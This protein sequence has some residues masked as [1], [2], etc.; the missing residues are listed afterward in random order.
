MDELHGLLSQLWS[1]WSGLIFGGILVWALWP[2]R[3]T[4]LQNHALIPLADEVP[5]P[6]AGP[7]R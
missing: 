5:L 4:R 6:P 2:S 7:Q 3:R 1:V